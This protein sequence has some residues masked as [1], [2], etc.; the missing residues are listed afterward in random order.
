[1]QKSEVL[2]VSVKAC[3]PRFKAGSE[4][5]AKVN[6]VILDIDQT[7]NG[8]IECLDVDLKWEVT[9]EQIGCDQE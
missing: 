9:A 7:V 2:N 6:R 3:R 4:L 8:D 1:M 5:S